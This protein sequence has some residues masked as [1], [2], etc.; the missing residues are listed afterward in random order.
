MVCECTILEIM[1]ILKLKAY[2]LS[3]GEL[4]MVDEDDNIA[5]QA[6]VRPTGGDFSPLSYL[7]KGLYRVDE[8]GSYRPQIRGI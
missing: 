1:D 5:P 7:S 2:H 6:P 4:E 3:R 8:R